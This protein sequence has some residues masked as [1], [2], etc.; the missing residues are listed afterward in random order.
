M[1]SASGV[2]VPGADL[3]DAVVIGAG[4]AGLAAADRLSSG[5]YSV[6]ICDALPEPGGLARSIVIGGGEIEAY[7]HHVFPQDRE[8]RE[9]IERLGRGSDLEWLPASTAILDGGRLYPFNS[10]LDLLR[11]SPLP[12]RGRIRLGL[13][14]A[15][16]IVRGRGSR[17]D[18]TSVGEA[19]PAWFGGR[20][21]SV[22]WRPLLEA[23]FGPYADDVALAWL[24][25]RMRQR[26]SARRCGTGDRLGYFRG[27]MGRLARSYAQALGTRGVSLSLGSGVES[28]RRDAD[29]WRVATA[30]G[31]ILARVV[32]ACTGG[33]RLADLVRLPD[34]Y[35]A[36]IE[37]IPYRGV[38]CAL[39]ELDRPLSTHYWINLTQRTELACL[40]VIEHTNF[41]PPS[42]YGGRHLVYLAHYVETDGRAW[43]AGIDKILS[44][45]EPVLA[46]IN[47]RFDRSWIV[48]SHLARDRWA[49]PVPLAGGPMPDL[50]L[51]TGLPGLFHASLAHIYPDDRGVSLALRLGARAGVAASGRLASAPPGQPPRR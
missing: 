40:A 3:F 29:L 9:L 30:T 49:Q 24:A 25:G 10:P 28:I 22:L 42:R 6:R 13:G 8:L 38:V 47:P 36:S 33:P 7:Y 1:S 19:G 11:F 35:R 50:P 48:A 37:A 39:L 46:A 31:E 20:G 16:A 27:G 12:L 41:V 18:R 26:A 51:D 4:M 2:G 14:S 15:V 5:G 32:V 43:S 17:L 34:R 21:Y 45:A 44:S 23:K